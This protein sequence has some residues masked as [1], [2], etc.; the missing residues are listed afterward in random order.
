MVKLN[1]TFLGTGTAIPT[2]KRRHSSVYVNYQ[3]KY[4]HSILFDCG[5]GT[6]IQLQKAKINFMSIDQIYVTHWH[7]DH[8]LGIFGL[9]VSMGFERREKEIQIF[10]P[11]ANKIVPDL[12]KFY[13]I[14]FNVKFI[15]SYKEGT[16]YEDNEIIV[17]ASK[18]KHTVDTVAYKLKEK[19]RFKL[20]KKKIKELKLSWQECKELKE[21]GKININKKQINFKDVSYVIEGKSLVY[22]GDTVYLKKMEKFCKDSFLIH[23]CTYFNK[24]DIEFKM[25]T[26]LEDVL[27]LRKVA[28]K[29]YLTHIGRKYQSQSELEKKVSKYGNVFIAKDLMKVSL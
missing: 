4:S 14:P 5:E 12:M 21:K 16:I 10:A 22:S 19:N 11:H 8:F 6:Q 17:Q 9:L 27:K 26:S 7:A 20:D 2:I 25:H 23:E 15:D 28:K 13:K 18:M 29:I 24:E 1:F 3:G